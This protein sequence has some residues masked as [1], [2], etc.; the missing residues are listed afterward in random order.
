MGIARLSESLPE[1]RCLVGI[2]PE[3][4]D[5]GEKPSEKVEKA[6]DLGIR[7]IVSILK[8]WRDKDT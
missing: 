8:S 4:V 3:S 1:K 7:E 2:E 6:I 5:W